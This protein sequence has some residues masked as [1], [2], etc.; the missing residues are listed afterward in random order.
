MDKA[1]LNKIM[2]LY[3]SHLQ[4]KKM[5]APNTVSLY[6][7]SIKL[8]VSFCDNFKNKLALPDKWLIEQLGI[9]E[10]EAFIHHQMNKQNWL[11]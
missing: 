6:L 9:R 8:F 3:K 4:V 11:L 10:I 7:N 2:G 5:L 1:E